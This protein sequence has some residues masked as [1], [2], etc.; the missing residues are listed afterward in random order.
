MTRADLA[1]SAYFSSW[2]P[3]SD[4][5]ALIQTARHLECPAIVQ[6]FPKLLCLCWDKNVLPHSYTP[7]SFAQA[8]FLLALSR[9][10]GF[11]KRRPLV[12]THAVY[13]ICSNDDYCDA[14]VF[15]MR[16]D[17]LKG[18]ADAD[19]RLVKT[20]HTILRECL[21]PLACGNPPGGSVQCQARLPNAYLR[22][23]LLP[24]GC[25]AEVQERRELW[26]R[27]MPD[28]SSR[29]PLRWDPTKGRQEQLERLWCSA[30]MEEWRREWKK[31][32][33]MVWEMFCA[34]MRKP[35]QKSFSSR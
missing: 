28:G 26:N 22:A 5:L 15:N 32:Q 12:T 25:V 27:F 6:A 2:H 18:L 19:K 21:G 4:V 34:R 11:H 7:P 35:V 31:A 30:C 9:E 20:G 23:S 16:Y 29:D 13:A 33:G 24:Q 10:E 8:V 17:Y 3:P 14:L 1:L